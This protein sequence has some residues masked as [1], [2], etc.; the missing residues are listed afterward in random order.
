M[1]RKPKQDRILGELEH[2]FATIL[3]LMICSEPK[4]GAEL[5]RRSVQENEAFFREIFEVVSLRLWGGCCYVDI[6][7]IYMHLI[8]EPE[9]FV[10]PR[11]GGT[12]L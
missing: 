11:A 2:L 1:S 9:R 10:P 8:V 7:S 12:R 3:G 4:A 5:V 6:Y